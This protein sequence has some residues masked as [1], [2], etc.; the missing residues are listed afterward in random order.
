MWRLPSL[1]FEGRPLGVPLCGDSAGAVEVVRA[2][3]RSIGCA[4]VDGGPLER[5]ELLEAMTAFAIGL[6]AGGADVR[7][8][9]PTVA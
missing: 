3:V 8:M 4:P 5:A 6:W 9:Y 7:S 2:L 1:T